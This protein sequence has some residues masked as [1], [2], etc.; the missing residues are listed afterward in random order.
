MTIN[1]KLLSALNAQKARTQ[2]VK[3]RYRAK[4]AR[5]KCN[6]CDDR[7]NSSLDIS[8]MNDFVAKERS[9]Y[10]DDPMLSKFNV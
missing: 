10:A 9:A 6:C 8:D 3:E 4:A 2:A 1:E 5:N 7:S